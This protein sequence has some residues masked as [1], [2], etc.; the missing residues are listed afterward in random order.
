MDLQHVKF[1]TSLILGIITSLTGVMAGSPS[2]GVDAN[3]LAE[4]P[5]PYHVTY[6][7][8]A[9]NPKSGNFE[10]ALCVWPMDLETALQRQ[11][12]QPIDLEKTKGIDEMMSR[13]VEKHFSIRP[14]VSPAKSPESEIPSTEAKDI[15]PRDDVKPRNSVNSGK[16]KTQKQLPNIRW[17]GHQFERRQVWLYFEIKGNAASDTWAVQNKLFMELNDD[18][19]NHVQWSIDKRRYET[20]VCKKNKAEHLVST[21]KL[22]QKKLLQRAAD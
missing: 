3:G 14:V 9:F 19:L 18:Q 5:H 8:L 1:L 2:H 12:S 4:S 20:F 22:L 21:K 7:E 15:K 17:V 11:D 6:T 13:Y 10:V 16:V